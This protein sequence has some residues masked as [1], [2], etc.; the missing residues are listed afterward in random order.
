MHYR[1]DNSAR[2]GRRD[3][4]VV[5]GGS[6]LMDSRVHARPFTGSA[7]SASSGYSKFDYGAKRD[8]EIE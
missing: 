1:P 7:I 4:S 8:A 6:A 5:D 3:A 2:N